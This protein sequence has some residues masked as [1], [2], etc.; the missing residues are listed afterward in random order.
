MDRTSDRS[1]LKAADA[2]DEILAAA[3]KALDKAHGLLSRVVF[4]DGQVPPAIV[5]LCK[6][7]VDGEYEPGEM[8]RPCQHNWAKAVL[9]NSIAC[10]RCG[11]AASTDCQ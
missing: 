7:W 10:T 2:Q 6:Q 3:M 4:Y 8:P 9:D 5:D 1:G 11:I